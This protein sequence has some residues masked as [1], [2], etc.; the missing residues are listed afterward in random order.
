MVIF[1]KSINFIWSEG[2]MLWR[3][4]SYQFVPSSS[5]YIFFLKK[6][7]L[8][9]ATLASRFESPLNN[10]FFV[11]FA[12]KVREERNNW[13]KNLMRMR[14]KRQ[15]QSSG[16]WIFMFIP[17][18]LRISLHLTL[19]LFRLLKSTSKNCINFIIENEIRAIILSAIND[20]QIELAITWWSITYDFM[21]NRKP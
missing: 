20:N 11:C 12:R 7:S 5:F 10:F 14:K 19:S 18:V 4:A 13:Y 8:L 15:Q 6:I 17:T 3:H 1:S 2:I 9:E 21:C 16:V